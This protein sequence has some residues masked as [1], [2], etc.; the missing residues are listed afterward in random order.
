MIEPPSGRHVQA[1]VRPVTFA[2]TMPLPALANA[3][4]NLPDVTNC[5]RFGVPGSRALGNVRNRFRIALRF[6]YHRTPVEAAR[7]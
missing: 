3:R 5:L 1:S 6:G 7:P 4:Q 2:V